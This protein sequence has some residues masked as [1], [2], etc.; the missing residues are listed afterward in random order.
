[1]IFWG[2]QP[3]VPIELLKQALQRPPEKQE[4][5]VFPQS[6]VRAVVAIKARVVILRSVVVPF[7]LF[8]FCLDLEVVNLF[9]GLFWVYIAAE[10]PFFLSKITQFIR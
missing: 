7:I 3:E 2:W 6:A 4:T 1:M 10:T 5:H 8:I 9:D